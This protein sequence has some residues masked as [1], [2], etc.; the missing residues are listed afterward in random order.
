[1]F[2]KWHFGMNVIKTFMAFQR[3]GGDVLFV[4][5]NNLAN[6]HSQCVFDTPKE[7]AYLSAS[8]VAL[9]C[10]SRSPAAWPLVIR[11]YERTEKDGF[12]LSGLNKTFTTM[13][14]TRFCADGPLVRNTM[15]D[16]DAIRREYNTL[17][18]LDISNFVEV[19]AA[20]F[21]FVQVVLK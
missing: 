17:N 15:K 18:G 19:N 16:P 20:P 2:S 4:N 21:S 3:R 7:G 13:E 6:T 5:F 8:G 1:M 11:D 12:D 10:L 14:T 9:E